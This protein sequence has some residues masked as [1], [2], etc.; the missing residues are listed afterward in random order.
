MQPFRK[1]QVISDAVADLCIHGN[2]PVYLPETNY[3]R[4]FM[5]TMEPR[6]KPICRATNR[7]KIIHKGAPYQFDYRSYQV[8]YGKPSTTLDPWTSKA[9]VSFMGASMHL[10]TPTAF[11]TKVM[12]VIEFPGP[13]TAENIKK[14]IPGDFGAIWI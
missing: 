13:H 8:K 6:R 4:R 3:F 7:V 14:Q 1:Q 9:T 10:Q 5:K 11:D 12:D 2:L